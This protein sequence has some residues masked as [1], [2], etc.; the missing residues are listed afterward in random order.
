VHYPADSACNP[1]LAANQHPGACEL[2]MA[3]VCADRQDRFWEFHDAVYTSRGTVRPERLGQYA[4]SA[5]L[6]PAAWA[7]CRSDSAARRA[8]EADL[9][10]GESLGI[11]GTPTFYL[12]GRPILGALKPWLIEGAI[13]ALESGGG[14]PRGEP[15]GTVSRP[16]R[17]PGRP[18][19]RA[20]T[21]EP[22]A[23]AVASSRA[24]AGGPDA[25]GGR[26]LRSGGRRSGTRGGAP[27]SRA[28]QTTPPPG[29]ISATLAR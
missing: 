23:F 2:S 20:E 26:G 22:A 11:E 16:E 9:R 19:S 7:A 6:D 29:N 5:G 8:I 27:D 14:Q 15:S 4:A 17:V 28:C 1:K 13:R 24:G 21:G 25:P 18:I 12:N 10:L 3:A